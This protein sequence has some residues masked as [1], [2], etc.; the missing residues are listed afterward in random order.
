MGLVKIGLNTFCIVQAY[1]GQKVGCGG[2]KENVPQ[3]SSS[4]RRCGRIGI[5][6]A[7]LEE[8]HHCDSGL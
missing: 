1:E 8:M 3:R 4:I 7:F 5:G 2:L 6:V